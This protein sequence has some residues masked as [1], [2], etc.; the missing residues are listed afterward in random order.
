MA[1]LEWER[2]L[3]IYL[4]D[5]LAVTKTEDKRV[6]IIAVVVALPFTLDDRKYQV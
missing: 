6:I 4:S 1:I 3:P 2:R 5:V